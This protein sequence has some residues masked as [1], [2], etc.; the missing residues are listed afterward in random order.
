MKEL[1]ENQLAIIQALRDAIAVM[2]KTLML[3]I[4][5]KSE[6][7]INQPS[8][9]DPK[10]QLFLELTKNVKYNAEKKL[11]E[12]EKGEW[13]I[14]VINNIVLLSYYRIWKPFY[15]KFDMG[16]IDVQEL[17]QTLLKKHFKIEGKTPSCR[18]RS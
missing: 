13:M 6:T 14:E 16:Y 17:M 2:E 10:E 7:L 12:N 4:E 3:Q 8:Q 18:T 15:E 9:V 1:I 11:W 5:A